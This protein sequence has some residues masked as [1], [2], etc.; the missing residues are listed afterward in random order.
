MLFNIPCV[1]SENASNIDPFSSLKMSCQF[2]FKKRFVVSPNA[3]S[4][5]NKLSK[6]ACIL[7]SQMKIKR[8]RERMK[9]NWRSSKMLPSNEWIVAWSRTNLV[10]L[11]VIR[12]SS[13][14]KCVFPFLTFDLPVKRTNSSG[15]SSVKLHR[16]WPWTGNTKI[17]PLIEYG[18]S[19]IICGPVNRI[20]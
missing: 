1:M 12:R 9:E 4:P 10:I 16:P 13:V 20:S 18:P 5:L 7:Y 14:Y 8:E 3:R 19:S 11:N 6:Y 2:S 15:L 17:W